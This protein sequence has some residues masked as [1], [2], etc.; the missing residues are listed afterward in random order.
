MVDSRSRVKYQ[1]LSDFNDL[2]KSVVCLLQLCPSWKKGNK[3]LAK[4]EGT[5]V[6]F[7]DVTLSLSPPFLDLSS[8]D[9]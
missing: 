8:N 2:K 4:A 3:E 1:M 7:V 5:L 9:P 6:G